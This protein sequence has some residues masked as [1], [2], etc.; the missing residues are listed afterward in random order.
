[1]A[2]PHK[3]HWLRTLIRHLAGWG[4]IGLGLIGCLVPVMP[5]VPFLVAGAVLLAPDVPLFRRLARA[6][7]AHLPM[8]TARSPLLARLRARLDS[9]VQPD[10]RHLGSGRTNQSPKAMSD[11]NPEP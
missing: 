1:M 3:P 4:L 9:V 2:H 11:L 6:L 8:A 5:Q 10:Q 7:A